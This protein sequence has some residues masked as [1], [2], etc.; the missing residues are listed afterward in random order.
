VER[1]PAPPEGTTTPPP[2][3]DLRPP[4]RAPNRRKARLWIGVLGALAILV[5]A[6]G[7]LVSNLSGNKTTKCRPVAQGW[8][9]Q[10]DMPAGSY[11]YAEAGT[12][13]T[14]LAFPFSTRAWTVTKVDDGAVWATDMNPS[15]PPTGGA[16]VEPLNDQARQ[17]SDAGFAEWSEEDVRNF[18]PDA[19]ADACA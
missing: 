7:I 9:E 19:S 6:G 11:V 17:D 5:V 3:T 1:P 16:F 2:D 18:F 15:R 10:L 4:P 13:A 14:S 8:V 12:T